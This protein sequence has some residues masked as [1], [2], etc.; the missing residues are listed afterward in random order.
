MS[1]DLI[2][3]LIPV[4][5]KPW[6]NK[7][8]DLFEVLHHGTH[9]KQL[10]NLFAWLLK[11]DETHQLGDIPARILIDEI[12]VEGVAA[13]LDYGQFKIFQEQDTSES[14]LGADIA[15]IV[16]VSTERRVA[17]VIENFHTSHGHGHNFAGYSDYGRRRAGDGV[18]VVV[19]LCATEDRTQLVDGWQNAAVV[20][21]KS[22]VRKVCDYVDNL[23]GYAENHPDQFAF[24]KQMRAH[25]VKGEEVNDEA[26]IEFV[27]QLCS[28]DEAALFG[29][30]NQALAEDAFGE[31]IKQEFLRRMAESRAMLFRVKSDLK[32][33]CEG[34]LR[35]QIAAKSR[36]D[37][38]DG[39]KADL[40]GNYQW[41]VRLVNR[42]QSDGD[43]VLQIC[44]GPTAWL[45]LEDPWREFPNLEVGE[46]NPDFANLLIVD[47]HKTRVKQS[48][49]TLSDVL[50]GLEG[51][52]RLAEEIVAFLGH[53]SK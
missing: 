41:A 8:F 37:I 38:F 13:P 21:H 27:K 4:L 43:E 14:T 2:N 29:M 25:F 32:L 22:F 24:F 40:R 35:N 34:D 51:D 20:T 36:E 7:P 26:S 23:N 19:M 52:T 11:D 31:K 53:K 3:E 16:M 47:R 48:S 49:I 17:I 30:T 18:S 28:V 44:F 42:A 46:P 12:N 39:V 15:D 45:H 50:E 6:G 5:T 1:R 33:Y 10:S 9:E